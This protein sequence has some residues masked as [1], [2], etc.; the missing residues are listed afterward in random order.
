M[1]RFDE[2]SGTGSQAFAV[3]LGLLAWLV[4]SAAGCGSGR[5]E[6]APRDI[7]AGRRLYLAIGCAACHGADGRGDGPAAVSLAVAPRNFRDL[8]SFRHG[9]SLSAVGRTIAQG[10]PGSQGAMPAHPFLSTEERRL[11]AAYVLSLAEKE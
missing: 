5:E 3:A 8:A 1:R 10:V 4:L 6:P 2:A 7:E 11:I 9:R